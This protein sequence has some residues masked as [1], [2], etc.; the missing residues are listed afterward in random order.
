[1][2]DVS[3]TNNPQRGA[4]NAAGSS[5]SS[6]LDSLSKQAKTLGRDIKN[7]AS[8]ITDTVARSA[9]SQ[10]Q[11]LGATAS[12]IA[13]DAKGKVESV[14]NEQKRAGADYIGEIDDAV[15]RAAGEINNE[16]PQAARYVHQAADRLQG[17]ASAVR[18][19]NMGDLVGEVEQFARQQPGLFFGGTLLLGFAATR[20]LKSASRGAPSD[21]SSPATL[22]SSP[23]TAPTTY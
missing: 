13:S 16:V 3:N 11:G 15:H 10:A 19:R 6:R 1:M 12:D 17:V 7:K 9:K 4:T 21:G 2:D 22:P 18:N 14:M 20:F 8:E 23:S 5:A